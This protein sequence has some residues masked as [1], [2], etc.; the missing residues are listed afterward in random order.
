MLSCREPI[1]MGSKDL[2]E[3]F[4]LSVVIGRLSLITTDVFCKT[5]LFFLLCYNLVLPISLEP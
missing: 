4:H 2:H 5:R 3:T 1:P